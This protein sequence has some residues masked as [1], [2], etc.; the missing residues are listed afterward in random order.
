VLQSGPV[1]RPTTDNRDV[2]NKNFDLSV[3]DHIGQLENSSCMLM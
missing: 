1:E 2:L 3:F